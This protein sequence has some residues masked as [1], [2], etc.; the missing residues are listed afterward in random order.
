MTSNIVA[1][2]DNDEATATKTEKHSCERQR[3]KERTKEKK[4]ED[5]RCFGVNLPDKKERDIRDH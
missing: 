2:T 5:R 3:K 1:V 4:T